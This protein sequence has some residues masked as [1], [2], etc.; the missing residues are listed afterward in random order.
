MMQRRTSQEECTSLQADVQAAIAQATA[1]QD[2]YE[3]A[4]V[5]IS[6]EENDR[7]VALEVRN[8]IL[9]RALSEAK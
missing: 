1:Y 6:G 4:I 2:R 5:K 9:Q 8:N 7:I 3:D